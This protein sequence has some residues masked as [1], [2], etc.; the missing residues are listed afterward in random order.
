M[1]RAFNLSELAEK[2]LKKSCIENRRK[3][4]DQLN[5][6]LENI[7]PKPE[8]MYDTSK[9]ELLEVVAKTPEEVTVINREG[10]VE[11]IN[12]YKGIFWTDKTMTKKYF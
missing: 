10:E 9:D 11:H 5:E 1:R 12:N 8:Y 6:I 3:S 2:N 4:S 7:Y